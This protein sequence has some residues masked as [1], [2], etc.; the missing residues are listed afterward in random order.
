M[1]FSFYPEW[2]LRAEG[3]S[4]VVSCVLCGTEWPDISEPVPIRW[5]GVELVPFRGRGVD[6]SRVFDG[7]GTLEI[8]VCDKCLI[9]AGEQHKVRYTDSWDASEFWPDKEPTSESYDLACIVCGAGHGPHAAEGETFA[10]DTYGI[11]GSEVFDGGPDGL[12]ICVCGPCLV[13]AGERYQVWHYTGRL[14][15][16]GT[17]TRRFWHHGL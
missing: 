9:R 13:R 1:A 2:E 3:S 4:Y 11:Y 15:L 14:S 8:N 7:P 16:L 17:K 12:D 5:G 6:G 10:F